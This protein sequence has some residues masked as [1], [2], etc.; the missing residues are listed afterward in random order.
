MTV[1]TNLH[2]LVDLAKE[3]SSDRRRQLLREV[4]H[5]F[6]DATPAIR[7]AAH[8]EY[9]AVLSRLAA[10]TAQDARE[11]LAARFADAP[12]APHGLV[13]Q[14]ARDVIDVAAPILQKSAA[15]TDEDLLAIAQESSGSHL[16]A[17]TRREAVPEAVSDTIV[18]RG[19]DN[20]VVSLV[21]NR[22]AQISR[23]AF[24]TITERAEVNPDLHAP[25][26]DRRE[27][28]TDL[29]NDL[30]AVVETRLRDRI[31]EKFDG[32]DPN[33]LQQ[34]I[35]ASH[36][37]LEARLSG[38]KDVDEARRFINGMKLRRQ[39]DGAL[40]VKLLREGHI[41]RCAAGLAVL[42]DID[43]A[44]AKQ[45]LESPSIDPLCL[46]C[47]AGGLDRS[48]FVTLAV[49]RNA[50]NGDAL[51]DAREYGR[52]FDELSEREAQRAMRFMLLRK[53]AEAA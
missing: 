51:R 22:G 8:S 46:V 14:L 18:R 9:D 11:E 24:E 29:L 21:R 28:P 53:K 7:S 47:R 34:A 50:G 45:A 39:L 49:L 4:T 13:L 44:T 23:E 19:D 37:R 20:V 6:F 3:K 33:E 10:D 5:H 1:E 25:L 17:I 48:L 41:L 36:A 12:E 38:D 27:M 15:L 40:V 31:L 43:L 35:D 42:T 30:M 52:I 16:E 26:V 32:I 2:K